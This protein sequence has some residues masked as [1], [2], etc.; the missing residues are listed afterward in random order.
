[1]KLAR[2]EEV[3]EF[4]LDGTHGSPERTESGIPV[5]SAQNVKGGVLECETDRFTSEAEYESFQKRLRLAAGD[6]LL[7][8]VGTIG[9][10][11]VVDAVYPLVFQRSVAIMRPR[12]GLLSA[13]YLYHAS[14]SQHFQDQLVRSSNQSSQAGI[15]LGKLKDVCVPV[16]SLAKQRRIAEIMDKADALRAKRR[17]ASRNPSSSTCSATRLRIIAVGRFDHFGMFVRLVS[18]RCSI[19]SAR[20]ART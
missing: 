18:V 6:V 1:V 8:I 4:I 17:A 3:T 2:L 11:A 12:H 20:R 5:L 9:R 13:R 16:P 14:Q 19:R 15:Y 10:A 7:T